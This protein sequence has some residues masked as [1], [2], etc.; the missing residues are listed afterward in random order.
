[1]INVRFSFKYF[2][3]FFRLPIAF[4]IESIDRAESRLDG[5]LPFSYSTEKRK[6]EKVGVRSGLRK[7]WPAKASER[8]GIRNA[9]GTARTEN[10]TAKNPP[11][12]APLVL[13]RTLPASRR[14]LPATPHFLIFNRPLRFRGPLLDALFFYLA[15]ARDDFFHGILYRA[16]QGKA[17]CE[18]LNFNSKVISVPYIKKC[19]IRVK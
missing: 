11:R 18:T 15:A 16:S 6:R 12:G 7:G 2:E 17:N 14:S 19:G 4:E 5:R 9:S 3:N 10:G 13:G 1:M 8:K